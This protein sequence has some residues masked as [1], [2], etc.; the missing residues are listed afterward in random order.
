MVI[1]YKSEVVYPIT[2]YGIV[3]VPHDGLGKVHDIHP[4]K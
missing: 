4:A 2:T 1:Y 3:L